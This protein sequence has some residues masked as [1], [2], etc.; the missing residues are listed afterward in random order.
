MIRKA[1]SSDLNTLLEITSSCAKM[2][3]SKGIFQWNDSYPSFSAFENDVTNNW[4]YVNIK[5]EEIIGCICISNFMD[6]EYQS[7]KWLTDNNN[8]IYIHRLA[9]NPTHQK[10]GYAQEM[11]SFAEGFARKNN[12]DSIRLDTFSKNVRNQHFYQKRD[13]KKLGS[14]FFPNQSKDPFYCYELVL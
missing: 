5:E 2:M 3:E 8:N 1:N 7:V 4:L 9:I 10:M 14:I 12:Y 13:Y 6:E 11:M